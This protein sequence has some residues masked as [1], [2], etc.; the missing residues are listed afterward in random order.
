MT[1]G[2]GLVALA[3]FAKPS[4]S[5]TDY[6]VFKAEF[7]KAAKAGKK[8]F[9]VNIPAGS[10]SPAEFSR[11]CGIHLKLVTGRDRWLVSNRSTYQMRCKGFRYGRN[12]VLVKMDVNFNGYGH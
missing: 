4:F 11:V 5:A 3:V 12:A 9:S 1:L 10:I 2:L 8:S 6:E 7:S